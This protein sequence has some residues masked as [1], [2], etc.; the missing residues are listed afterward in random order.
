M[1]AL[2]FDF[3]FLLSQGPVLTY[4]GII[5]FLVLTG[6][7]LPIPEEVPIVAAGVLASGADLDLVKLDPTLAYISCL[8]GAIMGDMVVY[9]IG[10]FL[11]HNF[12]R[13]H[14]WF[15]RFLHEEREQQMEVMI[16]KHGLKVFFIARFMVGVRAPLYLAAGV[17]RM[18]WKKFLLIDGI[19]A[20]IVVSAVFG[21]SYRYGSEI[22]HVLRTYQKFITIAVIL[23]VVVASILFWIR[24]PKSPPPESEDS[25]D[26]KTSD[27]TTTP[28]PD[29]P[30]DESQANRSVA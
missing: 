4:F 9:G 12:F 5:L 14:P 11:G 13:R 3:N 10:R 18:S 6:A 17:L 23:I 25:T 30:D 8:I 22:S 1:F 28:P 24:R 16:E 21:L 2:D 19:C 20:G 29:S 26:P 15:A 27:E 7:G